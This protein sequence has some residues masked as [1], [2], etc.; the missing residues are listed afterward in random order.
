MRKLWK[1]SRRGY[2]IAAVLLLAAGWTLGACGKSG[3]AAS[4]GGTGGSGSGVSGGANQADI[5]SAKEFAAQ[6]GIDMPDGLISLADPEAVYVSGNL[7]QLGKLEAFISME[8]ASDW[9]DSTYQLSEGMKYIS[10]PVNMTDYGWGRVK[11]FPDPEHFYLIEC[12]DESGNLLDSVQ[13]RQK[14][15]TDMP[16]TEILWDAENYYNGPKVNETG[17]VKAWLLYEV[18]AECREIVLACWMEDQFSEPHDAAFRLKVIEKSPTH[19]LEHMEGE[20]LQKLLDTSERPTLEDFA[21]FCPSLRDGYDWGVENRDPAYDVREYLGGWKCYLLRDGR[22][23]GEGLDAHLC[24]VY[25]ENYQSEE[26]YE[27]GRV[28]VR[29]DW[30]LAFDEAG[31]VRDESALPDTVIG[32]ERFYYN[33]ME[34]E[35]GVYPFLGFGFYYALDRAFGS[36]SYYD[37]NGREYYA[38]LVRRDGIGA[39]IQNEAQGSFT[40]LPGTDNVPLPA[41]MISRPSAADSASDSPAPGRSQSAGG[42]AAASQTRSEQRQGAD[43]GHAELKDFDWYFEDRLPSGGT[44]LRELQSLGGSWKALI[45]VVTA[46]EGTNQCRILLCDAELQYMGYKLTLPMEVVRRYQFPV[47]APDSIRVL[48]SGADAM[49]LTGDW[50]EDSGSMEVGSA[51]SGFDF[52]MNDFV[53]ADGRQYARGAVYSRG[54]EVGEIIMIRP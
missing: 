38:K 54:S 22:A 45:N 21:W 53:E 17:E 36:G 18:P 5:Q 34:N 3:K 44:R 37:G 42:A 32:H 26:G 31:G 25:V 47:N 6:Y 15:V 43:A 14:P 41:D 40:T 51:E 8:N 46:E 27:K 13:P 39:W 35:D 16:L 9:I 52:L 30:Y 7:I 1:R 29:I 19:T 10:V 20:E 33:R 24:N 49:N 12:R 2:F 48:E 11:E 23:Y 50:V 4:A 28:D